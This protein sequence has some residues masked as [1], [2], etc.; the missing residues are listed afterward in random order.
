MKAGATLA[1][2]TTVIG[3]LCPTC[4]GARY[5]QWSVIVIGMTVIGWL[6]WR[7]NRRRP[8]RVAARL[9][10]PPPQAVG[11]RSHMHSRRRS[12]AEPLTGDGRLNGRQAAHGFMRILPSD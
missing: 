7:F 11:A 3:S 9:G 2:D 5:A 12:I 6:W 8:R 1:V 10:N 4:C